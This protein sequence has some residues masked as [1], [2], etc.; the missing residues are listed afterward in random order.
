MDILQ[1]APRRG[2]G[3]LVLEEAWTVQAVVLGYWVTVFGC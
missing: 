1:E 2:G 3:R